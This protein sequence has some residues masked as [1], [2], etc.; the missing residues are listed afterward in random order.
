[1]EQTQQDRLDLME[2]GFYRQQELLENLA[3]ILNSHQRLLQFLTMS[4]QRAQPCNDD[5]D[6]TVN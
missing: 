5:D 1:M 2:A 6:K 3:Q 4:R